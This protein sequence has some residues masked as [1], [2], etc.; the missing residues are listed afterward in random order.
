MGQVRIQAAKHTAINLIA[1]AVAA[2]ATLTIYAQE[3]EL[4]GLLGYLMDTALLFTPLVMLSTSSSIQKFFPLFE[5]HKRNPLLSLSISIIIFGSVFFI[6]LFFIFKKSVLPNMPSYAKGNEAE[7]FFNF[8]LPITVLYAFINF[9]FSYSSIFK[10]IAIP[11]F[12]QVSNKFFTPIIVLLYFL[13]VIDTHMSVYVLI[14]CYLFALL[15]MIIYL[16]RR[17]RIHWTN[18]FQSFKVVRAKDYAVFSGFSLLTV[19]GRQMTMRID[20]FMVPILFTVGLN[21]EYRIAAFMAGILLVPFKSISTL[22]SP[23]IAQAWQKQ[24]L[25]DIHKMYKDSSIHSLIIGLFVFLI[26]Y[27]NL[28]VL[29]KL[30]PRGDELIH[31]SSIFVIIG[32]ARIVDL[33]SGVNDQV[34]MFSKYFKFN[35]YILFLLGVS[36]VVLNLVFAEK[37]GFIGIAMATSVS[38]LIF[39]AVKLLFIYFTYHLHPFSWATFRLGIIFMFVFF[40]LY[41]FPDFQNPWIEA[42]VNSVLITALFIPLVYAL[43]I[44]KSWNNILQTQMS[45]WLK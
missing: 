1:T 43:K 29:I 25:A 32:L 4:Y 24:D 33:G 5:K 37:Y 42:L 3:R 11:A 35:F 39:N 41:V 21:G 8:I 26:I 14:G 13:G 9:F 15:G 28:N 6:P 30:M 27:F 20:S 36:N 2:V 10:K 31:L 38:L 45:K 23:M 16:F 22:L 44:S 17:N 18:P 12:F 34:I 7:L 19:F 40:I